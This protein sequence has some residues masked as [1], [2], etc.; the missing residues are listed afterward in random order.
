MVTARALLVSVMLGLSA[1]SSPSSP[2]EVRT[3][4]A[5]V[6]ED[7]T[8]S[9]VEAPRLKVGDDVNLQVAALPIRAGRSLRVRELR[10]VMR[11]CS[12]DV[13]GGHLYDR[14]LGRGGYVSYIGNLEAV[15]P[16]RYVAMPLPSVELTSDNA[17]SFSPMVEFVIERPGT[18]DV[19]A[20]DVLYTEKGRLYR[21]RVPTAMT[22]S[23][24]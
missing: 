13:R 22:F 19:E 8:N 2:G 21:Q 4:D 6:L 10:P 20:V 14:V 16:S 15:D 11:D 23:A 17:A 24:T 3:G 7:A 5:L 12:V 9:L 18:C 1:C